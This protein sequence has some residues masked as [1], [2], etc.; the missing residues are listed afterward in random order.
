MTRQRDLKQLVRERMAKTGE[1]YAAARAQV[2]AKADAGAPASY[3]GILEG[4]DRFGGIQGDTAVLANVLRHAG[5]AC[6]LTSRPYTEA[7]IN[8]LCGGPGFLYAAFEYKGGPPMLSLA[9]RS[10]SMPDVYVAE[11]LS[12]LGVRQA[13]SETTSAKAARTALD[14]ALEA[15]KAALCVADIAS[16]PWYGLPQEYIGGG[17]H[18]IAVVGRDASDAWVDDRP[19]R[20][21]RLPLP[22]LDKA[23]A[24]YRKAKNRL[25]TI[26]G[27]EAKH[28]AKRALG[29]ALADT[30]RSYVEPA[31]P[32]SFRVNCGFSGIDKWRLLL[33]D[34]K[35]KKGWPMLFPEGP[36]AYAGLQRA[37]QCLEHEST[38]PNA[39][40]PFYADF[41]AEAAQALGAPRLDEAALAYREAGVLWAS[42]SVLVA[43][44]DDSAV[45]QACA[46]ADRRFELSDAAEAGAAGESAELWRK[47]NALGAE[48][49]LSRAAALALYARMA[50]V[51]REIGDAERAAAD[52]LTRARP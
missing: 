8:G 13:V 35:D 32:A 23:R 50:E 21:I 51:L 19:P 11:G 45:R 1:R 26:D 20:P 12:R 48:C 15:G 17:P 25:V 43:E 24:A 40:R 41:L 7:M 6:P 49:R 22:A 42:L 37:Y 2:L 27:A 30:A 31:V 52:C 10:R 39:G 47:R 29:A 28:D 36:L 3:P 5:V 33:T 34:T 38:A 46:I 44:C 18:L 14:K 16:L 4:Y 9:L